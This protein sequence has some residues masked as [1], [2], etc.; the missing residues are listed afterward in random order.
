MRAC[1]CARVRG[2]IMKADKW[3]F[4]KVWGKGGVVCV[5]VCVCAR[6]RVFNMSAYTKHIPVAYIHLQPHSHMTRYN[7]CER[8]SVRACVRVTL[9]IIFTHEGSYFTETSFYIFCMSVRA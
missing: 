7:K 2:D 6:A 8:A 5:C 1:L 4:L 3:I 9:V